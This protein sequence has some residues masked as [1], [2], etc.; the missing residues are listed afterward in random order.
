MAITK[1]AKL[2][3]LKGMTQQELYNLVQAKTG[4]QI[5]LYRISTMVN[6]KLTDYKVST[7]RILAKTLEVSTDDII[8]DNFEN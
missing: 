8:E 2:L 4:K 5:Q 7:A 1:L 6:G 3:I